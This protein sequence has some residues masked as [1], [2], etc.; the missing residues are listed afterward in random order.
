M[1]CGPRELC[2]RWYLV[3]SQLLS[4]KRSEVW[5]RAINESI[6]RVRRRIETLPDAQPQ[7]F[8]PVSEGE[9]EGDEDSS[10]DAN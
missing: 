8:C 6:R 7:D 5:I 2:R 3:V 9:C 10:P 4:S 1:L